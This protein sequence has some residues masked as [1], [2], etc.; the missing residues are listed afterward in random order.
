[1]RV[2]LTLAIPCALYLIVANVLLRTGLLRNA[3]SGSSV[4]FAVIGDSTAL[5]LDYTSAYSIV[6]GRV[7]VEGLT[8]R[9]RER[10][11]EWFLTLDHADV[12]ISLADLLHRT[13]HATRLRSSGLVLRARMRLDR[14]DATPEVVATLPPIEGFPDAPV[15]DEGPEPPPL[16]DA[17]YNLWTI[18]LEDVDVDHVRQIWIQALRAE[19]DTHVTGRWLFHPQRELDVGPATVDAN[20]VD[21]SYGSAPLATGVRGSFGATVHPFDLRHADGLE[22]L[23]H[24]SY[25]GQLRGRGFIDDVLR[26]LAPRSGVRFTRWEGP[27]D[28]RLV[29]DHGTLADGTHVSTEADDCAI[30]AGALV[31]EAPIRIEIGVQE[32]LA[33]ID[34]R[35]SGLRVSGPGAERAHLA[36][37][38]VA[39]TSRELRLAHLGG[40]AR[41]AVDV[42]GATTSDIAAWQHYFPSTSTFAIRSGTVAADAHAKGS[43]VEGGGWAAG[44]A[45]VAADDVTVALG[46]AVLGGRLEAHV[47]LQRATWADRRKR[48]RSAFGLGQVH[49]RGGSRAHRSFAH[50]RRTASRL[51]PIRSGRTGLDRP[52]ACRSGAPRGT[53]RAG[54][55]AQRHH[56]R[57]RTGSSEAARR[58]RAGHGVRSGR[59]QARVAR[60]PGARAVDGALRRSRLH[61][62]GPTHRR[63]AGID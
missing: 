49:R 45:T 30:G 26:L 53:A 3:V 14:A 12:R 57:E 63:S 35:V 62:E 31:L 13:F 47:D 33:T 22:V 20:G 15:L 17:T 40:D 43:F 56:H 32:H 55:A 6:P 42:G 41:F 58:R 25:D 5:R 8:I 50:G 21:F 48:R 16:T 59:R 44:T 54:L 61:V 39:V 28:A 9:G 51:G 60:A 18:D 10:T 1:V 11:V 2:L 4:S 7:H 19:G 34:M 36:S 46:P 38:A 23:D 24:V 27:F 37:I 29:L 52:A